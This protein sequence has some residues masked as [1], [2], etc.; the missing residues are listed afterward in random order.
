MMIPHG[1]DLGE[2]LVLLR[3]DMAFLHHRGYPLAGARPVRCTPGCFPADL[4]GKYKNLRHKGNNV[5]KYLITPFLCPSLT[6]KRKR[7]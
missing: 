1:V 3:R 6:S 5:S 2:A 4:I 7:D